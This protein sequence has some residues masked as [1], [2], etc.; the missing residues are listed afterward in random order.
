VKFGLLGLLLVDGPDGQALPSPGKERALLALL[1]LNANAPVSSDLAISALWEGE[2][3]PATAAKSVQVYVSRLRK[4]LGQERLTT[5]TTGYVL[6]VE[7]GELDVERFEQLAREG[8][9]A[10]AADEPSRAE[11]TLSAALELWRG[12]AL[13]DFRYDPFAQAEIRRLEGLRDGARADRIDA[14]LAAGRSEAVIP[15]LESLVLEHP[16]WERPRAQLML[17]LYRCGR[18]SEALE[19]YRSTRALLDSELGIEP[20]PT[21]QGLEHAILNQDPALGEPDRIRAPRTRSRRRLIPFAAGA[22]L[23]VAAAAAAAVLSLSGGSTAETSVAPNSLAILDAATGKLVGAV[24]VVGTPSR[25]AFA[26]GVA[27]VWGDSSQTV[28]A[29][30]TRTFAV[31]RESAVAGARADELAGGAGALWLLDGVGRGR[32]IEIDPVYGSVRS[33]IRLPDPPAAD[34]ARVARKS[35]QPPQPPQL[36]AGR[37]FAVDGAELWV[38]DG[39]DD[40]VELDA[41]S[42]KQIRRVD[43]GMPLEDVVAGLG[44]VWALSGTG[45]TVLELDPSSGRIRSRIRLETKTGPTAPYPFALVAGEGAVWVLSG[46]S[47]TVTR[48]DPKL[49]AVTAT[50]PLAIGSDPDELAAGDGAVWVGGTGDGTLTRIDAITDEATAIHLGGAVVGV[51]VSG[52]RVVATVQPSFGNGRVAP[53]ATLSPTAAAA[54]GALPS[55]FCSPV[56][57][58]GTHRPRFLIASDLPMQGFGSL[59][60][61]VQMSDVVRYILAAHDFRAGRYPIG[62]QLCDDSSAQ[63]G[64]WSSGT[65]RR[66]AL[67]E[68]AAPPLVGVLGPFNSGC[69]QIEIPIDERGATGPLPLV[70]STTTYVGLTHRGVG[71]S[72][73]EPGRYYPNGV[74]NFFRVVAAD[75][76]QGAADADAAKRLGVRKLYLLEDGSS[77]ASGL[78]AAVSR[79]AKALGIGLAG[80]ATWSGSESSYSAL[81]ARIARTGADGVFVAGTVDENGPTLVRALRTRLGAREAILAPDGFTP[82]AALLGGAGAAAEG[83][84]VSVAETDASQLGREGTRFVERFSAAVGSTVQ[85]YSISAAQATEVLLDAIARSDGTRASVDSELAAE[86]VVGGIL[87]TFHFD[88]NGDT[89]AGVVTVYRIEHGRPVVWQVIPGG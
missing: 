3:A 13:A 88:A 19:L 58:D 64:S 14:R 54:L 49:G 51:A 1:L 57:Y 27:W 59:A 55:S 76:V 9:G 86:R 41:D 71:T 5:A 53:A 84:T 18:Q 87:G 44:A 65:C 46:N 33:R 2:A 20:G 47:T 7:P 26:G 16:L 4:T 50:I 31:R 37:R 40:L 79:R 11:A 62:Y 45:A 15:E 66:N 69:A 70:S 73:G 85:P 25:V 28:A 42:G 80:S 72:P 10:L 81:V 60:L 29:V 67:A 34:T 75:D 6:R 68:S 21:L 30:N 43:L 36:T 39:A 56:Y 78:T 77:Y 52:N 23:L 8:G 32:L 89:N 83:M 35:A 17:A 38:T 63:R 74:R 48:I 82:I 12:P 61:T 22:G 24:P